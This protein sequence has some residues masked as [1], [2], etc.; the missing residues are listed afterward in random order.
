LT[1]YNPHTRNSFR[2]AHDRADDVTPIDKALK[3]AVTRVLASPTPRE[4]PQ[5][6]A[7]NARSA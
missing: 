4:E 7:K 5:L 1:K 6:P 3:E 2:R